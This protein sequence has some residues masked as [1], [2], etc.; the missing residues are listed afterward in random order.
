MGTPYE[1]DIVAWA[2]EQAALLR[3]GRVAAIDVLNI[4]EEIEDVGKSAHRELGSRMA[5]L[6]GHLLKWKYQPQRRGKSWQ[7][8]IRAQRASIDH[9][10]ATTPS[11]KHVLHNERWLKVAWLDGVALAQADTEL[12]YPPDWIWPLHQ[13]LDDQFLPD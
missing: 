3:A 6:L 9:L 4:A 8:T 1:T 2:N 13:V 12:D 10:L 5:V 11:L 7:A